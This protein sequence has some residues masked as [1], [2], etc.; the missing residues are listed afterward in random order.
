M[1]K[2]LSAMQETRLGKSPWRRK[3]QSTPVFLLRE[4]HGQ[5]SLVGYSPWGCKESDTTE[6]CMDRAPGISIKIST[7]LRKNSVYSE[8]PCIY[9]LTSTMNI[10]LDL[11]FHISILVFILFY[12]FI[13]S[14]HFKMRFKI[15]CNTSPTSPLNASPCISLTRI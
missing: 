4:F 10:L 11:L 9:K 3:W 7:L 14:S 12:L 2:N 6:A 15:I 13:S 8:H 1:V 5:R